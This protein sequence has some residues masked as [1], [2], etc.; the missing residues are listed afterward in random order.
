MGG[1]GGTGH[2]PGPECLIPG[3]KSVCM[4]G[5]TG[6]FLSRGL[7]SVYMLGGPDFFI[8]GFKIC[9]YGRRDGMFFILGLKYV[10]MVGATGCFLS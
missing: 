9:L 7:K 4:A 10:Y 5:G 8:P 2:L 1:T 3:L 6:C